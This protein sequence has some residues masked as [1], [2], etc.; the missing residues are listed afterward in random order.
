MTDL[1]IPMNHPR[2]LA[3][4]G[5]TNV[6]FARQNDARAA[7][8]DMA[9]LRCA[10]FPG[11][12][13][14]TQQY[15]ADK[16]GPAPRCVAIGIATPVTG[17]EVRMTNHHWS[18]SI[19]GLKSELGADKLLVLNDFSALALSLPDLPAERRR[20]VGAG[21]PVAGAPIGV[22]GPGSGLGVSGL[23]P[24]VDGQSLVPIGGEGGHVT[25]AGAD[26]HEHA[27]L[28]VLQRRFGHA[29][30]E[31]ALSGPGLENLYVA[32]SEVAGQPLPPRSAAEIT[33]E[34]L[35]GTSR[36]CMQALELFC[37]LLGT[38]AGNLALT[39]GARGG[40]YIGGG[41]VPRL[42]DWFERSRFR[43]RFEAKG[44]F[45]GYLQAIPTYVVQA[46]DEAA[47][48][49]AARALDVGLGVS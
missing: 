37:S 43:E 32:L 33:R 6:R 45:R 15:L 23:L 1:S 19:Q 17:D 29:S 9:S 48:L 12:L 49:G 18:F 42:G 25:L 16:P 20:Q 7:L 21:A 8:H 31:R 13:E 28:Q 47:L 44:R 2:L 22:L 24:G 3:D 34:A 41:I 11:L 35:A 5:G 46:S 30:A 26:E 38:V 27:V 14:A 36:P 4:V 10:D 40:V 39:L